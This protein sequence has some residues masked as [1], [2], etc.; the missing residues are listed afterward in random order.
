[1]HYM[2]KDSKGR[3]KTLAQVTR[4]PNFKTYDHFRGG[5]RKTLKYWYKGGNVK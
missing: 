1:M 4:S 2:W 3:K 5:H